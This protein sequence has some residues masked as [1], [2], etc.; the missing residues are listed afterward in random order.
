MDVDLHLHTTA[1]DGVLPAAELVRRAIEARLDLISIT[2]HDTVAGVGAAMAEARGQP[3]EV[4]P[5]IEVSTMGERTELHILGYFV[6]IENADL[7]RHGELAAQRRAS[8]L[9]G[10][11]D[12]LRDQGIEVDYERVAEHGS[13]DGALGRPHLARALV[14]M[15]AVSSTSEAFDRYIGNSHPAYIPSA[16]LAPP[17]AISLIRGCG[18]IAVWAHPPIWLLDELLPSLVEAGLQGLEVYRP[19]VGPDRLSRLEAAASRFSLLTTGGS[20]WHSP[21]D[22]GVG[23]FRVRSQEVSA[24]L[25]ARGH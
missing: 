7:R 15:G 5:G 16:L 1:S 6:D 4:V 17:E 18:G 13:E 9:R 8:R 25:D 20:D 22:G 14:E 3:I 12:R 10:M 21:E 24:F 19:R 11:V 23:D 2:D